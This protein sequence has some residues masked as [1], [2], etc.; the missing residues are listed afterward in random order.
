MF[1]N[2]SIIPFRRFARKCAFPAMVILCVVWV[3]RHL[4]TLRTPTILENRDNMDIVYPLFDFFI[5]A[6][7]HGQIEFYQP[8]Q[9]AGTRLF[10]DPNFQI[11]IVEIITGVLFG[12]KAIFVGLNFMWLL[13]RITAALGMHALIGALC[14]A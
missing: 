6:L 9:W 11:N 2:F 12:T 1:Y 8:F 13:E 5:T 4:L 10:G 14:P 3:D 7:R